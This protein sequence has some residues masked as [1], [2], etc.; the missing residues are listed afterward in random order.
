MSVSKFRQIVML[1]PF[2]EHAQLSISLFQLPNPG[3]EFQGSVLEASQIFKGQQRRSPTLSKKS[4][5]LN[6]LRGVASGVTT[7]F[8]WISIMFVFRVLV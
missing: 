1:Y 6:Q 3:G 5:T 4:Q 8:L 7:E 2:D